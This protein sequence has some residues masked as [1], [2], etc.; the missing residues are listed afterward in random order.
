MLR[1]QEY[2]EFCPLA[3]GMCSVQGVCALFLSFGCIEGGI[4]VWG[5]GLG[6][7]GLV[8]AGLGVTPEKLV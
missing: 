7:M 8:R 6:E 4:V 2:G 3:V 1:S 5:G